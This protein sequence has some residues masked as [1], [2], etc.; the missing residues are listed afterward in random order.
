MP[1]ITVHIEVLNPKELVEKK[2]GKLARWAA[3]VF[4]G[5]KAIKKKVEDQ[6]GIEV[7]NALQQTL[8]SKLLEEGVDAKIKIF[9]DNEPHNDHV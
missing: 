1:I 2:K 8:K 5:E 6:V 3:A 4:M 9:L 7:A